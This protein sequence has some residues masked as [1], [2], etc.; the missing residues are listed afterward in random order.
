MKKTIFIVNP[1][2]GKGK[3][4]K[5]LLTEI[6]TLMQ[7]HPEQVMLY[8]T[9]AI[10]DAQ[11]FVEEYYSTHGTARFIACGG[12]G[13]FNEVLNGAIR[14]PDAEIGI[15]P[16]GTGNDF[17]RNFPNRDQLYNVSKQL[18]GKSIPC[19]AIQF[20]T[21]SNGLLKEGYCANMFNIGFDCNVADTTAN[22]KKNTLFAGSLAYFISIFLTLVQK[23]CSQ[24][25]IEADGNVIHNGK[26]LLTSLANGCYC[27]GG[28]N[29][30]PLASIH[31]GQI[32]INIINNLSRLRFVSLLPHYMKGTFLTLPNIDKYIVSKHFKHITITPLKGKLRLCIDGEI[33][34]AE[35]TEFTIIPNA[36]QFILPSEE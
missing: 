20:R 31:D 22:I 26:L 9:K 11:C 8:T 32:N 23:K 28:I 18:T 30:N 33:T 16:I 29:S 35:E 1:Y 21:E 24:L 34:D 7:Q 17:S 14:C 12:D 3:K 6:Q 5:A 36:F 15:I 2:A 10:G 27:G 25:K 13:T 19:D 4:T